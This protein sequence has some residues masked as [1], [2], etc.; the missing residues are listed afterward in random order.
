MPLYLRMDFK[1]ILIWN[2][3]KNGLWN[4]KLFYLNDES[5][6]LEVELSKFLDIP[7]YFDHY[8]DD[9]NQSSFRWNEYRIHQWSSQN[10][11]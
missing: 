5:S 8:N 6:S 4:L 3:S 7:L 10:V 9:D 11:P 2:C 1:Q